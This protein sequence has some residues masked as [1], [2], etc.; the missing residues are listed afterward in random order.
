MRGAVSVVLAVGA[1]L[2]LSSSALGRGSGL[3]AYTGPLDQ[4]DRSACKREAMAIGNGRTP[5]F[6]QLRHQAFLSCM[7]R[8]GGSRDSREDADGGAPPSPRAA[9][10]IDAHKFCMPVLGDEAARKACMQAHFT[11]LAPS[12]QQ[13]IRRIRNMHPRL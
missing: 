9:C 4:S 7:N 2:S 6:M 12:C 3:R 5:D 13:A 1:V 8:V 10:T 11:E